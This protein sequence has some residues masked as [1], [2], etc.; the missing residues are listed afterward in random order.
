MRYLHCKWIQKVLTDLEEKPTHERIEQLQSAATLE[1]Q[2]RPLRETALELSELLY[3]ERQA[4]TPLFLKELRLMAD[5][6]IGELYL[7]QKGIL[8]LH[9]CPRQEEVEPIAK[10]GGSAYQDLISR[11]G[12]AF[13]RHQARSKSVDGFG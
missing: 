13:A 6:M 2:Q 8:A 9:A 12:E 1:L 7:A 4:S 11:Y 10:T 3:Y 5:R